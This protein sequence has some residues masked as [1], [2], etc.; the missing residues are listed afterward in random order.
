MSPVSRS[1][2]PEKTVSSRKRMMVDMWRWLYCQSPSQEHLVN[3]KNKIKFSPV[4]SVILMCF[5][6]DL[7]QIRIFGI[8]ES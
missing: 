6:L 2:N 7:I 1:T 4:L 8:S 3:T 5:Y